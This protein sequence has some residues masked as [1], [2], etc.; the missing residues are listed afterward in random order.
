MRKNLENTNNL[1]QATYKEVLAIKENL[2]QILATVHSLS[3][4][5]QKATFNSVMQGSDISEFFP[6]ERQEQLE[7][8]MDRGHPE[9]ES[10]K[11]E[12]YHFLYTIASKVKKGFSR[13][14]IKAIFSR[15][16]ICS[17]KWPSHGY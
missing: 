1:A 10:R 14:V 6:V 2:S 15:Q 17:V 9:W 5:V 4:Q 11:M 16:Y 3:L 7:L 12:F 13:G 8:F